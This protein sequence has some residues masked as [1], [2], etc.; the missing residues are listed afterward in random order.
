MLADKPT[1]VIN[2]CVV[3]LANIAIVGVAFIKIQITFYITN[4]Y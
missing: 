1:H 2:I 3:S 4:E